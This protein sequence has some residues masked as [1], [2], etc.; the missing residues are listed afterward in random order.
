MD[1]R[2]RTFL[3]LS[4]EEPDR[5]PIDF[6]M[7]EGLKR[8]LG[9]TLG[10]GQEAFLNAHDVDLRYI[11]GPRYIGPPLRKFPDGSEEDL[12]GVR[13][14][15]VTVNTQHG[16][17]T[18]KEVVESPLASV[19]T[20][21]EVNTYNH[22]PSPDWFDYG[23][24]ATQCER[25]RQQG[26]VVLFMGDRLNRISQLKPAIYLRG[27]EEL[28][29][30]LTLKP[31][32]AKVMLSY[33]R[34]FYC[35]YVERIFDAAMGKL[36]I[37]LMGDDF[38]S[39]AG[40]LISPGMWVE[41]LGQGFAD[42]IAIAKDSDIL[43]MHHTCGGVRPLVPLMMERGL[44]ILQSLQPEAAGMDLSELKVEYGKQLA[45]H[46]GISIQNTLPFGTPE[47]ICNE[48]RDR[49]EALAP[50]GGYILC[51]AHNIQADTPLENVQE[52]LKAYRD[53][54]SYR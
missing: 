10:L 45:F 28:L 43:V 39:Q 9:S 20:V 18:Y 29:V 40:P 50:G 13:R 52:L 36:D 5:V 41:F 49:V 23:D 1:S 31:E 44:D 19:A 4:F 7:S 51:T 46:G 54:G 14:Q 17:E 16:A 6:W 15:Q 8:G 27:M 47:D 12:W 22:W 24:I 37:L 38:G 26:R 35:A 2:E 34:D 21:E 30:D 3:A 42:Y 32:L 53:Y 11:E 48:V 33:I 25:I